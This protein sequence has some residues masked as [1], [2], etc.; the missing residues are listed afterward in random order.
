MDLLLFSGPAPFGAAYPLD[1]PLFVAL[2]VGSCG[3]LGCLKI[4]P[5]VVLEFHWNHVALA[6]VL[7]GGVLRL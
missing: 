1:L 3:L 6:A 5:D 7:Y 4:L 2:W